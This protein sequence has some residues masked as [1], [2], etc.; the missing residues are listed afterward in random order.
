[1]ISE[2][3]P[4]SRMQ[5]RALLL[6]TEEPARGLVVTVPVLPNGCSG[7]E[8]GGARQ[9]CVQNGRQGEENQKQKRSIQKL[10]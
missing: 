4:V 9:C 8:G 6:G 5:H 3:E 10:V 7:G 1:M 2:D